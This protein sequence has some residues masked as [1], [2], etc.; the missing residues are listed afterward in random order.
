MEQTLGMDD[1]AANLL[2]R[3]TEKNDWSARRKAGVAKV[4]RTLAD[5]AD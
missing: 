4:A 1:D 2:D 5:L 3:M